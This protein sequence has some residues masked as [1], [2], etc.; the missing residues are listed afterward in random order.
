MSFFEKRPRNDQAGP[1]TQSPTNRPVERGFPGMIDRRPFREPVITAR[2]GGVSPSAEIDRLPRKCLFRVDTGFF[3][4]FFDL[5]GFWC[6]PEGR[7]KSKV[8][9]GAPKAVMARLTKGQKAELRRA[10]MNARR[11][12]MR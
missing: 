2:E 6:V 3:H 12:G 9:R 1:P 7:N 5:D 8:T 4:G 11:N 10:R